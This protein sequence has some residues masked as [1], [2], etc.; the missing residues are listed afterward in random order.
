MKKF[1][2]SSLISLTKATLPMR[3]RMSPHITLNPY[4]T[5]LVDNLNRMMTASGGSPQHHIYQVAM[6]PQLSNLTNTLK[7]KKCVGGHRGECLH[8]RTMT[9]L[10]SDSSVRSDSLTPLGD[11]DTDTEIL[12]HSTAQDVVFRAVSP[13]GHVYWEIDPKRP[14]KLASTIHGA[15]GHLGHSDE[16]THNDL[17][18][19]SDFSEDDASKLTAASDRSRQSSSRFSDNRPLLSSSS[20]CHVMSP[21]PESM[22]STTPIIMPPYSPNQRFMTLSSQAHPQV[23]TQFSTRTRLGRTQPRQRPE[24]SDQQQFQVPDLRL[25][26]QLQ[27]QI[28]IPD[29][30][31]IP[32]SVKSSEY[33]MAKIQNHMDQSQKRNGKNNRQ[34]REV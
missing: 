19:M 28:Q 32:V 29:L 34:E 25:T 2:C 3:A 12:P 13:H 10:Q 6:T 31:R 24:A 1:H 21:L 22:V 30:R 7:K 27:Q 16:D 20:P 14:N 18:N 11:N 9:P 26:E 4:S 5:Q 8:S 33:I 15:A 17:H 23:Q